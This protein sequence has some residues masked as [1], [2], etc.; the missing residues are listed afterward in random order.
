MKVDIEKMLAEWAPV[1]S[2]DMYLN[3]VS[4]SLGKASEN[5]T[6]AQQ[7]I[8]TITVTNTALGSGLIYSIAAKGS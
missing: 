2:R 3:M 4:D 1:S 6:H 7:Q 8:Q 5:T